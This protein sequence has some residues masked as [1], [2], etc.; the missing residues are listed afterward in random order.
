MALADVWDLLDDVALVVSCRGTDELV[1]PLIDPTWPAELA[2][3]LA[4]ADV[5]HVV[6]DAV[7]GA[8]VELGAD[9]ARVRVVRPAVDL[10]RWAGTPTPLDGPPW[11]LATVTRF[12]P[13]KGV[14]D[15]VAALAILRDGGVD[16]TLRLVGEGP[17]EGALRLRARRAGLG[18]AVS[19]VGSGPTALVAAE[20]AAAH[21]YVSPS[22]SEGISNGVL[23]AMAS[24][25]A[26][27]STDVGGMGEVITQG[28]DGWLVPP[29]RPDQL[30]RAVAD[31]VADP[32]ATASV[33]AAG[34]ARVASAFPRAD[35]VSAWLAVYRD[36]GGQ[37]TAAPARAAGEDRTP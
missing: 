21:L 26:V 29:G 25:V 7:A 19:F 9:P 30:A 17:Q 16:A 15:L 34:R 36:L 31:A 37:H 14:E 33:A 35:Q 13:A 10:A 4:R 24:G 20:L 2:R 23:E 8:V 27:V 28:V 32:P 11:R 12:V 6:A 1:R 3:V 22:L 18:D 5:V